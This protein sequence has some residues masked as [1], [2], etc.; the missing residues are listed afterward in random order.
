MGSRSDIPGRND[1]AGRTALE[2]D[3]HVLG[4]AVV[5]AGA[6][7]SAAL[8]FVINTGITSKQT[9]RTAKTRKKAST[10]ANMVCD[11]NPPA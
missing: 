3:D 9:K 10:V 1:G 6:I 7:L 8:F 2:K 11:I 5:W 4:S